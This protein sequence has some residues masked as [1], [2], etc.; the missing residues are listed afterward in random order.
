MSEE[1][2]KHDI[3]VLVEPIGSAKMTLDEFKAKHAESI[4]DPGA[5]WS[6]E[7]I[8]RLSWYQPFP[9]PALQGGFANGDVCWFA[10][11]KLNVAYNA[12]DR[13]CTTAKGDQTALLWEGDEPD[14]IRR[15]TYAEL[16]RKV[17][18]IANALEA[19]G[20]RKG[21]VVTLYMPMSEWFLFGFGFC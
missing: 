4:R 17:S 10:G 15:I 20:V 5:F 21:D 7:A 16:R 13:H 19:Q 1:K 3:P 18:Q 14:D 6:K 2:Q 8:E 9:Q 11:G 12:I